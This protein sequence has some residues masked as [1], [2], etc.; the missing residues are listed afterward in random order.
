ML[1][2]P[3]QIRGKSAPLIGGLLILILGAIALALPP[4]PIV[5]QG[6]SAGIGA[7]HAA[8]LFS[9]GL[10]EQHAANGYGFLALDITGASNDR[11]AL[12]RKELETVAARRFPVWAWID[13]AR[14]G[15][16]EEKLLGSLPISGVFLY[17]A[18]AENHAALLSAVRS[19]LK[20]VVVP[21]LGRGDPQTDAVLVDYETYLEVSEDE[22][23]RPVL[24]AD[25]LGAA[26]VGNAVAHARKIAGDDGPWLLVARIP[27][28][29]P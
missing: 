5:R 15:E 8:G 22:F 11:D 24:I 26:E 29:R 21:P 12:W 3:K 14:A 19:R 17:G 18:D 13:V 7:L 23:A 9:D 4:A 2:A 28:V 20:T 25:Q 10:A 27:L 16:A 6:D 1:A